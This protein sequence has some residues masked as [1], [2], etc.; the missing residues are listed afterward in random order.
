[1]NKTK[2]LI[3]GLLITIA[4]AVIS[5]ITWW[6]LKC[7]W[8]KFSALLWSFVYSLII[9]NVSP[10]FFDEKFKSGIEF[11]SSRILRWSIA[12]L[13]LTVS[14]AVWRQ[15]GG[16]GIAM[17]LIN[18]AVVF[19]LGLLICKYVLK[20][21]D[22]LT[23]L[24][25]VGTAICGAT[26]IA[27]VGPAL[28]AK[29]EQMGLAVAA[30][31][32]FGLIAMFGYPILFNGVLAHW[33]GNSPLAYGMW[34]G[35]GIHETAQVIAAASQVDGA[36]SIATS[37]KFIRIFMI[38]PM[39]IISHFIYLRF[40]RTE[41]KGDIKFTIPW[42]ALFFIL[43]SLVNYQLASMSFGKEWASFNTTYLSP[44][45]TF[46]LAWAF[47]G[48]GLKVNISTIRSLG[49]KAFLGGITV[50]IIAGVFSLLLVKYFWMPFAGHV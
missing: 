45:I 11:A 36:L 1:M 38:G 18:L 16:V 40:S 34:A 3:P 9:V 49:L 31:T 44:T 42:F 6:F 28:R 32:L 46:L 39:V 43:F 33:L 27:A 10:S 25:A 7:T 2:E 12:A 23:I 13:G 5:F 48:I 30:I 47:A 21:D 17:V 19:S 4:I 37:A 35:T 20:M 41:G 24:V 15:L 50:A 29:A 8:L 22:T 26:A 14:A